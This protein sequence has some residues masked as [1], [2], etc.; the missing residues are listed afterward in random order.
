[1]GGTLQ[2]GFASIVVLALSGAV[3]AGCGPAT[4]ASYVDG[5]RYHQERNCF[6]DSEEVRVGPFE[7]RK[8]DHGT[9]EAF[10][11]YNPDEQIILFRGS[12]DPLT[13]AIQGAGYDRCQQFSI[14]F[15]HAAGPHDSDAPLCEEPGK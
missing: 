4:E 8:S 7:H 15:E 3:L 1:M 6:L 10:C 14:P 11:L 5:Y 2:R 13:A 9:T 12:G